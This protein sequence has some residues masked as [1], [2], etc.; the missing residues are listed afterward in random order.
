MSKENNFK[1]I[2]KSLDKGKWKYTSTNEHIHGRF[3][4]KCCI[5]D[6]DFFFSFYD[7]MVSL[8]FVL[9]LCAK[10]KDMQQPI[11]EFITRINYGL[12]VGCFEMDFDDGEIRY[13]INCY[14]SALEADPKNEFTRLMLIPITTIEHYARGFLGV[15][16]G[17]ASPEEAVK[18]CEIDD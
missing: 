16:S 15:M 9:P 6:L 7:S 8:Y 1:L 18:K 5:K 10:E 13:K 17:F 4:S 3:A 11:A 14:S 2:K 12:N